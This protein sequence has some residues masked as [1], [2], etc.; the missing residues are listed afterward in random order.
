M[1]KYADVTSGL[2]FPEGPVAMPDGSVIVTEIRGGRLTR[3]LP[4]GTK[5]TVAETGGGPNGLAVGPDGA[6]YVCNNG[7]MTRSAPRGSIQRVDIATG[8]VE[9]LYSEAANAPLCAPNDIVFD[10]HG[11]FWF[12]DHGKTHM[13]TRTRDVVG[14]FYARP[15]GSSCREVIFPLDNPNGIGLSPDGRTLFVAETY[16]CKLWAFS[17]KG[18]GEIEKMPPTAGGL[19]V[20]GGGRFVYSPTGL[21]YF[22]SMAVEANGNVCAAMCGAGGI[23]VIS[24]AGELVDVFET[25]DA[26]TTNICFGGADMKTAWITL[27]GS[28]RLVQAQWPRPGLKL[29]Y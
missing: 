9:T 7:G 16:T 11:G 4:D 12:T 26:Y 6:L 8:K 2:Q 27:S 5:T 24:P 18:P 21:R 22:D 19:R 3:V 17:I 23:A 15:D 29:N 10:T 13:D 14:V 25:D 1:S 28:G 20:G